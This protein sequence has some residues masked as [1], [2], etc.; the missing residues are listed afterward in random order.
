[1]VQSSSD[2][3]KLKQI[4]E[5]LN[6][7]Q[8]SSATTSTTTCTSAYCKPTKL[9]E[10]WLYILQFSAMLDVTTFICMQYLSAMRQEQMKQYSQNNK[11]R[12]I[13]NFIF[14]YTPLLKKKKNQFEHSNHHIHDS[15]LFPPYWIERYQYIFDV[16]FCFCWLLEGL[17]VAWAKANFE[18]NKNNVHHPMQARTVFI[19]FLCIYMILLPFHHLQ[20]FWIQSGIHQA[21]PF[22]SITQSNTTTTS[23]TN[24]YNTIHHDDTTY[25]N[26]NHEFFSL[27][28]IILLQFS[29]VLVNIIRSQF[30]ILRKKVAKFI[31]WNP[32]KT[33]RILYQSMVIFKGVKRIIPVFKA[34]DILIKRIKKI[35]ILRKQRYQ[36]LVQRRTQKILW[37]KMSVEERRLKACLRIQANFRQQK[38]MK[39]IKPMIM[40]QRERERLE[41]SKLKRDSLRASRILSNK[42]ESQKRLV[43]QLKEKSNNN[44][45]TNTKEKE[46]HDKMESE[47]K[48]SIVKMK[49]IMAIIRPNSKFCVMW[50]TFVFFFMF[51]EHIPN[52][53]P[54]IHR[55]YITL[56]FGSYTFP[57]PQPITT[58]FMLKLPSLLP[59]VFNVIYLIDILVDF[60]TGRFDENGNLVPET[61]TARWIPFV[62]KTI[63]NPLTST[64]MKAIL[65]LCFGYAGPAR[66]CRWSIAFFIPF[67][68]MVLSTLIWF[69]LE[70]VQ[71]FNGYDVTLLAY[72]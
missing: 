41:K 14:K 3:Q 32:L 12:Q 53:I 25:Y 58:Y 34:F 4:D 1:M 21:H 70:L 42:I 60:F 38:A 31:I 67:G 13:L 46:L 71:Y 51:I 64:T 17:R 54:L 66:I 2:L 10:L 63:A 57:I 62:L 49:S 61:F 8:S 27:P 23:T 56:L 11:R 22:K 40:E 55:F 16:I 43:L 6:K 50:H 68:N 52:V 9:D 45:T 48:V 19:S 20:N 72:Q 44:V 65:N 30:Y 35:I 18:N 5:V 59:S 24:L 47:L 15:L 29:T 37:K 7:H 33:K 39:Q 28:Y 26:K 36:L 69:W